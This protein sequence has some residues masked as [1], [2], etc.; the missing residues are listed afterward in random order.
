WTSRCAA[1]Q[2][3]SPGGFMEWPEPAAEWLPASD[4]VPQPAAA[5]QIRPMSAHRRNAPIPRRF[6]KNTLCMLLP[7]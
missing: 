4:W 6:G 1:S 3:V 5:A 7:I 2:A